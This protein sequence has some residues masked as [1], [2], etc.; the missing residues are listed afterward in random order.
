MRQGGPERLGQV[1]CYNCV[2]SGATLWSAG[3]PM[4][5]SQHLKDEARRTQR[6][7]RA[8]TVAMIVLPIVLLWL[9]FR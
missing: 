4:D 7:L 5:S 6:L 9:H 1:R 8:L 3:A 2:V